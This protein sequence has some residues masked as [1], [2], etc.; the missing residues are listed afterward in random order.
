VHD[1]RYN[2]VA[3]AL[4]VAGDGVDTDRLPNANLRAAEMAQRYLDNL[5]RIGR[6][7]ERPGPFLYTVQMNRLVLVRLGP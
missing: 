4:G 2:G 6:A 5:E 7:S 3:I 1:Q